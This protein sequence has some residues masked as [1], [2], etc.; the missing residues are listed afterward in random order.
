MPAAPFEFRSAEAVR[1]LIAN[2]VLE[3]PCPDEQLGDITLEPHQRSAVTRLV[4]AIDEFGGAL[5]ADDVGLGK[6]FVAAAISRRYTRTLV[7]APAAL[8][9]MWSQAQIVAGISTDFI[10]FERLSRSAAHSTAR[11]QPLSGS[12]SATAYDFVI[13]DECHHAR[14]PTTRRFSTLASIIRGARTLLL[15]AT[16][17]H[18]SRRDLVAL[19]SLFLGSR[20]GSL[21]ENEISRC[22]V[23]RERP[24]LRLRSFPSV[25]AVVPLDI[26]DDPGLTEELLAMPPPL[27]PRDGGTAGSLVARGLIHQWASSEAALGEAIRRRI[28]KGIAL[29]ASLAAG[30]YPTA[31]ELASW[32]Y[33]DGV[34]QLGFPELLAAPIAAEADLLVTLEA[35]L[36]AL[37]A[38]RD[39]HRNQG[40]LDA[41]RA[42]LLASIRAGHPRAK[43]VAF[44]Q[45]AETVSMFYQYLKTNRGTAM[46]TGEG[47]R[48]A[49]GPLTR[50]DALDRFSP[51]A[52][53]IS[54]PAQAERI[55]LLLTT[56]LLSEGVN[57]QDAEVVVH[58][59]VP[60][61][62]A[63]MEQRVGR[64]A[65]MGSVHAEVFVYLLRPPASASTVLGNETLV[66]RKWA[67]ARQ[68]VGA[69]SPPPLCASSSGLESESPATARERLRNRLER[70]RTTCCEAQTADQPIV[71][72]VVAKGVG[73]IAVLTDE[74]ESIL[75]GA[76]RID[77]SWSIQH[78]LSAQLEAVDSADGEEI[79]GVPEEVTEVLTAIGHW[80]ARFAGATTAGL[81]GSTS[82]RRKR[83]LQRIDTIVERSLPHQRALLSAAAMRAR[84]IATMQHG[85]AIERDL[86]LLSV[87]TLDAEAWLDRIGALAPRDPDRESTRP[88]SFR[89]R[90][91]LLFRPT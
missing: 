37:R 53:G 68:A 11:D 71:A 47:A 79:P 84:S 54:Q 59:D 49:G 64:A 58:L 6:T 75:V 72:T 32:E 74:E 24:E 28:A 90:A 88:G 65:R 10:S 15:S 33:G 26:S 85:R 77:G 45:Y 67:V 25:R 36:N 8:G 63:R 51:R 50:E 40:K 46:L 60:W 35:H 14:T 17:I 43:V 81:T 62:A 89:I 20:A 13:V 30:T 7:V 27:P 78:T 76:H 66:L 70:W 86:D 44:A 52:R 22:V 34:L 56:D 48:V 87:S 82:A 57:L 29:S 19:L 55:D 61:T 9:T 42:A 1:A 80:V 31:T 18:N 73:F 12:R 3:P 2:L 16:P 5:L 39:H 21:T 38:F 4:S 91:V 41:Q 23:R 83:L 69:G